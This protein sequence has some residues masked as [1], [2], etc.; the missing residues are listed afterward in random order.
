MGYWG[1]FGIIYMEY[2]VKEKKDFVRF[3]IIGLFVKN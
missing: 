2:K 1:V 3:F